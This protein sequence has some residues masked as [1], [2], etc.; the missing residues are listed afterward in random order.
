M[1]LEIFALCC[2]AG[3]LYLSREFRRAALPGRGVFSLVFVYLASR[4]TSYTR[5]GRLV[6]PTINA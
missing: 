5:L 3:E 1:E 2:A 6:V 4:Y